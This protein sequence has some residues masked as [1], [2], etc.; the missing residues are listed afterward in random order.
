MLYERAPQILHGWSLP[1]FSFTTYCPA[2]HHIIY[3]IFYIISIFFH[4]NYFIYIFR[5]INNNASYYKQDLTWLHFLWFIVFK[6]IFLLLLFKIEK[7]KREKRNTDGFSIVKT[8][9]ASGIYLV[10]HKIRAESYQ[11]LLAGRLSRRRAPE[12]ILYRLI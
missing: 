4:H 7:G 8:G 6:T 3:Y 1:L 9:S 5:R 12:W 10:I 2:D 11:M